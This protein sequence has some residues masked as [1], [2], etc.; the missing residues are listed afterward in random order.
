[1]ADTDQAPPAPTEAGLP[2]KIG[3]FRVDRRLGQGASAEVFLATHEVTGQVVALK[4]LRKELDSSVARQVRT[5]FLLEERIAATIPDPRIVK[6]YE[7]SKPGE[8]PYFI[9]MEYLEADSFCDYFKRRRELG[10]VASQAYLNELCRLSYEVSKAMSAAHARGVVHRDLKPDNVLVLRREARHSSERVKIVDFG[11]AKAPIGVLTG[12]AATFTPHHTELGTVMGSPPYMSPEQYG[13]AHAVTGKSDVFA[14]GIMLTISAVGL[15]HDSL[16]VNRSCWTLPDDFERALTLGPPL[17]ERLEQLLRSM[18]AESPEDRPEMREVAL[19]L[20]RLSQPNEAVAEAVFAY[21]SK[22]R[23]PPKK[24]L[25]RLVSELEDQRDLTD[26]ENEFVRQA[27]AAMLASDKPWLR[28]A[29]VTGLASSSAALAAL[30]FRDHDDLRR[31]TA[32]AEAELD[33]VRGDATALRRD[34]E[35]EAQH[36]KVLLARATTQ[37]Q[38]LESLDKSQGELK[39]EARV[40]ESRLTQCRAVSDELKECTDQRDLCEL[41]ASERKAE[42]TRLKT[43]VE[44]LR[45]DADAAVRCQHELESKAGELTETANRLRLCSDGL[46]GKPSDAPGGS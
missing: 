29:V 10:S 19:E 44:T 37:E 31:A 30:Y 2:T 3:G 12:V 20:G 25:I 1:M 7:T 38:M 26:D 35:A 36:R 15:D 6:V 14:L 27:P 28:Y 33:R 8:E 13:R 5:R 22:R 39:R 24:E 4:V 46:R 40:R 43:E 42:V 21:A 32:R 18:V 17:P 45:R 11:I 41:G 34:L 16:E 9:A 23:I